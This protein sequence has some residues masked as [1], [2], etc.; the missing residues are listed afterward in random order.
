MAGIHRARPATCA[1]CN[2]VVRRQKPAAA[3]RPV[4][5][6]CICGVI[7][8]TSGLC[9]HGYRARAQALCPVPALAE[10]ETQW[11]AYCTTL[12]GG[13]GHNHGWPVASPTSR[14]SPKVALRSG[15]VASPPAI[16]GGT[17]CA[18]QPGAP[19]SSATS[20][21]GLPGIC[22]GRRRLVDIGI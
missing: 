12:E 17:V 18:G 1:L 6:F 7:P 10:G 5:Q 13:D 14:E 11:C 16:G 8:V 21:D 15:F 3:H 22:A 2:H 19:A 9:T 4:E 20:G